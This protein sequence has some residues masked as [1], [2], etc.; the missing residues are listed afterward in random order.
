MTPAETPR[1]RSYLLAA[2]FVTTV[3]SMV[4][5]A[6]HRAHAPTA[7][8]P[9]SYQAWQVVDAE[10]YSGG[11]MVRLADAR[12]ELAM[13]MYVGTSEGL[14]IETRLRGTRYQRPLSMDLMDAALTKL[15]AEFV[16]VQIDTIRDTAYIG[17]LHL[18]QGGRDLVLDA[19]PSDAVVL[20]L[21]HHQPVYVADSV[22]AVAAT[23]Y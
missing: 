7:A 5:V 4:W 14:A 3:A 23:H 22:I 8:A 19:R 11:Y 17:S 16:R 6:R 20:A 15:G 13:V 18:R 2:A 1:I 21:A 12:R 9:A 10:W